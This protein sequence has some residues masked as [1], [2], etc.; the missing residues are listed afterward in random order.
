MSEN[1]QKQKYNFKLIKLLMKNRSIGVWLNMMFYIKW[2]QISI[3]VD[4]FN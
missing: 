3:P 4:P 1:G 2:T